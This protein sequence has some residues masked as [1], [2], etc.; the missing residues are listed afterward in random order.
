MP[1]VS[2][3]YIQRRRRQILEAAWRCFARDGFHATSMDDVIAAAGVSANVVYRWFQGKDDLVVAAAKE[4]FQGVTEVLGEAV[5]RD[6]PP[7]MGD[8]VELMIT[9]FLD[10]AVRDG[11]DATALALQAWAESLRNPTIHGMVAG[12][13]SELR[14]LLAEL[15]SRH[16]AAGTISR[17]IDPQEAAHPLFSMIPGFVLQR[18]LLGEDDPHTYAQAAR[19]ILRG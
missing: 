18:H 8:A 6:P 16:Q 2:D 15:I 3:Q 9:A 11:Q 19:A 4:V 1:R 5:R 13:Y 17:D 10:R 14:D 7:S 12:L